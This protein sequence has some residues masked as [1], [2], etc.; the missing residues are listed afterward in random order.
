M[1]NFFQNI[2]LPSPDEL[3]FQ[4]ASLILMALFIRWTTFW[5]RGSAIMDF[6]E[7]SLD[8]K[9]VKTTHENQI[10]KL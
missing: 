8:Q 1:D 3:K 4:K 6:T 7:N 5:D 2:P 9:S 10:L